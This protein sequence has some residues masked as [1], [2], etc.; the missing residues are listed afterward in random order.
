MIP[1]IVQELDYFVQNFDPA[2]D[3]AKKD[4]VKAQRAAQRQREKEAKERQQAQETFEQNR[5]RQ[6]MAFQ[7]AQM[8]GAGMSPNLSSASF[9]AHADAGIEGAVGQIGAHADRERE[10]ERE[11]QTERRTR[12][13]CFAPI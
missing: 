9:S 4:E 2:R 13:S 6:Q 8:G 1:E 12:H 11:R 3:K 7:Q 10:R 5:L